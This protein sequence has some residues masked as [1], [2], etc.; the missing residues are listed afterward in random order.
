LR[1]SALIFL[2]GCWLGGFS[3][4]PEKDSLLQIIKA[5]KQDLA[6]ARAWAA[7]SQI[8]TWNQP[9]SI[10]LCAENAIALGEKLRSDTILFHAY[11]SKAASF[12][13]KNEYK[14][15]IEA[16]MVAFR[17]AKKY[18]NP[19]WEASISNTL[20]FIYNSAQK[21][22]EAIPYFETSVAFNRKYNQKRNLASALNNLA[23]AH[24]LL[25]EIKASLIYRLEAI[26]LRKELNLPSALGDSYS[27]LG[28]TYMLLNQTD[29]ALKY[30]EAAFAIKEKINDVEM[31][32]VSGMNLAQALRLKKRYKEALTYLQVAERC[33]NE[34]GSYEYLFKVYDEMSLC[35]KALGKSDE[36][37]EFLRKHNQYKDSVITVESRKQLNEL[38]EQFQSEKKTF[39]IESLKKEK[40][41]DI[42]LASERDKRKNSVL[43]L[44]AFILLAIGVYTFLLFKR[45]KL[46][47]EQKRIIEEQKH[48][49]EEKQKEIL[50]SIHYARRI[51]RSLITNE[52][53]I[54]ARLTYLQ[55]KGAQEDQAQD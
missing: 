2:L 13:I 6:T 23:N 48:L 32:A 38:T 31:M 12:Y 43:F 51:Q 3:Q 49:V 11:S 16:G 39:E 9:D 15:G 53:Y 36:A 7:L 28:E 52:K 34:L 10:L 54:H 30:F 50:D 8:M 44:S 19:T 4:D 22:R 18:N 24:M 1:K 40:Q 5:G 20:G 14:K 41:K 42:E 26:A 17:L 55:K 47:K 45:F 46:T 35:Y 37:Y 21:Y 29:S 25:K 27:D 33:S